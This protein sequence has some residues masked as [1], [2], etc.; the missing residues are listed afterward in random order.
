MQRACLVVALSLTAGCGGRWAGVWLVGTAANAP[1][2]DHRDEGEQLADEGINREDIG[3]AVLEEF[4]LEADDPEGADLSFLNEVSITLEAEGLDPLVLASAD[5]FP[6]GEAVVTPELSGADLAP[7]L[8]APT[9]TM[10]PVFAGRPPEETMLVLT[11]FTFKVRARAG[12]LVEQ[13]KR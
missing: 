2:A 13:A 1:P 5:S 3:E 4:W 7:Y 10:T 12:M 8:M 11:P 6:E 9:M